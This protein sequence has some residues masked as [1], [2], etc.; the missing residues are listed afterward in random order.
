MIN[1]TFSVNHAGQNGG[2]IRNEGLSEPVI[3]NSILWNNSAVVNG[4]A[5]YNTP[6]AH[7]PTIS[8]SD[9]QGSFIEGVWDPLLGID[10]GHNIDANPLLDD[11]TFGDLFIAAGSP[12]IDAGSSTFLPLGVT[13]DLLGNYRIFGLDVD[14]GPYEI[15]ESLQLF[16]PLIK[17]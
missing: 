6:G 15:G 13:T 3:S 1:T 7:L 12:A 11:S 16:Y 8:Y 14:M 5:I 9:I 17:K 2:G 10:G 4:P